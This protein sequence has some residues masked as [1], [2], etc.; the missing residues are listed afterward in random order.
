MGVRRAI[1]VLAVALCL[2]AHA[3]PAHANFVEDLVDVSH[4]LGKTKEQASTKIA[5]NFGHNARIALN[6]KYPTRGNH[7]RD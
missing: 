7:A 4:T 6:K 1:A 3:A 2:A 5:R